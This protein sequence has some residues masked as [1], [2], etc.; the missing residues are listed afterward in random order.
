MP[1]HQLT[2]AQSEKKRNRLL[3]FEL[4][5]G[6]L[7]CGDTGPSCG[8]ENVTNSYECLRVHHDVIVH[9]SP[10]VTKMYTTARRYSAHP[11][12]KGQRLHTAEARRPGFSSTIFRHTCSELRCAHT[13]GQHSQMP[14]VCITD[15][16]ANQENTRNS[17]LSNARTLTSLRFL[18]GT[19]WPE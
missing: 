13:L 4:G 14:L 11:D 6:L 15:F 12:G 1:Q 19:R 10:T 16:R 2:F 8:R 5:F 7:V 3:C 18:W 9:D 17:R